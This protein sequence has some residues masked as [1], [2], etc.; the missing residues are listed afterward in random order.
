MERNVSK[1]IWWGKERGGL[2]YHNCIIH[3]RQ[4]GKKK[5]IGFFFKLE[6][7]QSGWRTSRLAFTREREKHHR[8]RTP[9]SNNRYLTVKDDDV[10]RK[11][12]ATQTK[13]KKN[14]YPPPVY[15]WDASRASSSGFLLFFIFTLYLWWWWSRPSM[16]RIE[17][18]PGFLCNFFL[19]FCCLTLRWNYSS[20]S[21]CL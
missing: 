2:Y 14:E 18:R 8:V 11:K 10:C 20:S 6:R 12:K 13:Q 19:L 21:S 3:D 1:V 17:L 7:E 15:W 16:C 9:T 4:E 5:R